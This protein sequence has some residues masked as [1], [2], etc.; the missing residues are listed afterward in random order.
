MNGSKI[1]AYIGIG[2]NIGN[3]EANL[4]VAIK[5]LNIENEI[6]VAAVS[7]YINTAP[8]GYTQQPD[9][10]NAA[11]EIKTTLSAHKL[12]EV[13]QQIELALKRERIIRW[14]PRTID[15]DILLFDDLILNEE[16]LTIPHPRM[17]EREFVLKPLNEIAPQAFHPVLGQ[18]VSEIYLKNIRD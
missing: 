16:N 18:V 4:D 3:R 6:E 7:S 12:L 14:G 10:L 8:V 13:C 1:T 11:V 9:F 2:T 17:H 15:L 5:M